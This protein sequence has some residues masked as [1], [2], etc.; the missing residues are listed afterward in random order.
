[1][2]IV[3][4]FSITA[5]E[6]EAKIIEKLRYDAAFQD[7]DNDMIEAVKIVTLPEFGQ[8][9]LGSQAVNVDQEISAA[10]LPTLAYKGLPDYA[11]KDTIVWTASDGHAYATVP[12]KI[13]VT[14]TPVNDPPEIVNLETDVLTVNAGEGPK[15]ISTVFEAVDVDNEFLTR[16]EIAFRPQNFVAG[17]DLLVF[18]NTPK[19]TGEYNEDGGILVLTGTA[20]V[21]E[22]NTAIR[23]VR[24]DNVSEVFSTAE[25]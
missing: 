14:I 6:D 24:Y 25:V 19:I 8:L 23:T 18:D 1:R 20:T 7:P 21:A 12:A 13:Y 5:N 22:Y 10:A 16:A 17:E 9:F 11:D 4:D 15:E 3:S 2:P